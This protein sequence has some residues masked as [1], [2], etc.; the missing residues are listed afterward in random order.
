[1][2][3]TMKKYL[4]EYKKLNNK[5]NKIADM[6]EDVKTS[7]MDIIFVLGLYYIVYKFFL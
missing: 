6:I 7:C 3:P 2:N 5:S 4:E 1:M